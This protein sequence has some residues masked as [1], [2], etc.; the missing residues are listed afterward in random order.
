MNVSDEMKRSG[1]RSGD[2]RP[3]LSALLGY[4]T[5]VENVLFACPKPTRRQR[6]IPDPDGA[7]RSAIGTASCRAFSLPARSRRGFS[8]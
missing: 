3:F 7:A 2:E 6:Q 1:A 4:E 5:G 8:A